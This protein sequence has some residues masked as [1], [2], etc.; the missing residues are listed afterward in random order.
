MKFQHLNDAQP[1]IDKYVIIYDGL[2]HYDSIK[3]AKLVNKEDIDEDCDTY[4]HEWYNSDHDE[5]YDIDDYPFWAP[6]PDRIDARPPIR[7]FL[8]D[9][10]PDPNA[11]GTEVGKYKIVGDTIV[12]A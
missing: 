6:I 1:E 11:K 8:V 3:I 10:E 7:V 12:K 2:E 4:T 9:E 5:I